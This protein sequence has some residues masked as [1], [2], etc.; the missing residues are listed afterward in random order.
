MTSDLERVKAHLERTWAHTPAGRL[1]TTT[2]APRFVFARTRQGCIWRFREDLNGQ[3]L[4]DLAR[5]AGRELPSNELPERLEPMR[6]VLGA[7]APTVEALRDEGHATAFAEIY[8][9]G[10]VGSGS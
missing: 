7:E 5:L 4:R 2:N 3:T 8:L 6:R 9:F 10:G 1:V